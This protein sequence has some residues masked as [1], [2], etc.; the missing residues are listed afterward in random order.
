MEVH[1]FDWDEGNR[2]KCQAHGL[3]LEEIEG[4][5]RKLIIMKNNQKLKAFPKLKTDKEAEDFVKD[6]D[7][8]EYYFRG[9]KSMKF[10][11]A[12][13][14]ARINMRLPESLL[15]HIKKIADEK[16]IPYTRLIRQILEL[17]VEREQHSRVK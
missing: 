2:E 14:S 8:S 4:E 16:K 15:E 10:E 9:F 13:K 12:N 6:V 5:I 17:F 1:G 7:L 3:Q 11:F